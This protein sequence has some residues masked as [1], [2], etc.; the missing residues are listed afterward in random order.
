MGAGGGVYM[1]LLP[2]VTMAKGGAA[3]VEEGGACAS[4]SGG[5]VS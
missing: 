1:E 3:K 5:V 4:P 2:D